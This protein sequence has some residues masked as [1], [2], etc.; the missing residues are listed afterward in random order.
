MKNDADKDE[1]GDDSDNNDAKVEYAAVYVARV[2]EEPPKVALGQIARR[3]GPGAPAW[4]NKRKKEIEN[5]EACVRRKTTNGVW[6]ARE[7]RRPVRGIGERGSQLRGK[8]KVV[9]TL[10]RNRR[11]ANKF[12]DAGCGGWNWQR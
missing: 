1:P 12:A 2:S 9:E 8:G 7:V 4:R 6:N 3:Q 5:S 10:R 11:D